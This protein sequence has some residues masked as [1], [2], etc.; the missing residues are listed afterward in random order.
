MPQK[1]HL[2]LERPIDRLAEQEAALKA[3]AERSLIAW[4]HRQQA[5]QDETSPPY[6]LEQTRQHHQNQQA[7]AQQLREQAERE[8]EYKSARAKPGRL[9]PQKD[10]EPGE[11]VQRR[12]SPKF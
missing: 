3:A 4:K 2:P 7:F 8:G 9:E 6:T 5:Q 1:L 10:V 12:R 11:S